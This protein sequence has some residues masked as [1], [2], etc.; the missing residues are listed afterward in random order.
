[1]NSKYIVASLIILSGF[2]YFFFKTKKNAA[3][4]ENHKIVV[5]TSADY[6]P[7]AFVDPKRNEIV[8]FD[9]DVITEVVK[10]LGKQIE[11]K[12]MPFASLVFGLLSG[13]IDIIAAGMSPSP[14]RAQTVSF[15]Q[16][17]IEPDPFVIITKKS[18][19]PI[20]T[21]EQLQGKRVAV[22]TGY[23]AE[24]YLAERKDIE[25]V[26][27]TNPAESLMALKSCAIDAFVC[28]RSVAM[29]MMN[30]GNFAQE[31]DTVVIPDTGDG[32][33]LALNKKNT[34]W[35]AKVNKALQSMIEDG[36]LQALKAKWNL[37]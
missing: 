2:S 4:E 28:A 1:M 3:G 27:L 31:L 15:S 23:T 8:G 37:Q 19:T 18:D 12:D 25:L 22:N 17:Y 26:R 36:T 34:E 14:K 20:Q 24:A 11:I 6:Q 35:F 32:C 21:I 5:G 29:T 13:D 9:I 10:R 16:A 33:A 7:F 30:Q